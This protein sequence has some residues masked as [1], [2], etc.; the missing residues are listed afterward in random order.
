M[1]T[2][3]L[4]KYLS[5]SFV[6]I[7]GSVLPVNDG[8]KVLCGVGSGSVCKH[9]IFCLFSYMQLILIAGWAVSLHRAYWDFY[10]NNS[11]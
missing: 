9:I 8:E 6:M 11:T 3:A 1:W 7:V 2:L 5:E 4:Q 10:K